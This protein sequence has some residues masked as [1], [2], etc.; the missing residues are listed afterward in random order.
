VEEVGRTEEG[1]RS[2][3]PSAEILYFGFEAK[4]QIRREEAPFHRRAL[5]WDLAAGSDSALRCHGYNQLGRKARLAARLAGK[6][7]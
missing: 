7:I 5:Q 1:R 6:Q 4:L 3:L 2:A